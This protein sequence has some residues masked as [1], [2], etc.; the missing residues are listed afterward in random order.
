MNER[1]DRSRR[2]L[3]WAGPVAGLLSPIP[4]ALPGPKGKEEGEDEVTPAEEH[5]VKPSATIELRRAVAYRVG[6]IWQELRDSQ[7]RSRTSTSGITVTETYAALFV[8]SST[9]VLRGG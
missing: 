7:W 8:R 4:A 3:L 6:V 5:C 9:A 1:V 2:S